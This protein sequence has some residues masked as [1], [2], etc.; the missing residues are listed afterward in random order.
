VQNL[1][2]KA[3]YPDLAK[4]HAV[5]EEIGAVLTWK[6][7]QI[8]TYFK[9]STGKLKI[10]Q[11]TGGSSELIGYSRPELTEARVSDYLIYSTDGPDSLKEILSKTLG[12]LVVVVK[13][14]TLYLWKNVRIHL[15]EVKDLGNFIEFEAVMDKDNDENVSQERIQFLKS[16]FNIKE[17]EL[18]ATGYFELLLES[19]K[20]R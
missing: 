3:K 17:K 1:E 15:D 4:A 18:I 8:D 20:N 12:Q 7:E 11:H 5:A 10:R 19:R 2:L 6:K 16:T 14:R 13:S 9:V